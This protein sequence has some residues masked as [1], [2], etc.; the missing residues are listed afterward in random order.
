MYNHRSILDADACFICPNFI[1]QVQNNKNKYQFRIATGKTITD[2]RDEKPGEI[3]FNYPV[4]L[5]SVEFTQNEV[6][7]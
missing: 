7:T 6:V 5:Y 1:I 4:C 3:I 2:V